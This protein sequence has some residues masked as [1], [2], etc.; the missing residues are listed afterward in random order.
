MGGLIA[1]AELS[2]MGLVEQCFNRLA[3]ADRTMPHGAIIVLV[4]AL[5]LVPGTV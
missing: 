2:S 4:A 1:H 3:D 5:L